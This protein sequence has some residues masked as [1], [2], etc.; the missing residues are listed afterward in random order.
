M[1]P[2]YAANRAISLLALAAVSSAVNASTIQMSFTAHAFSPSMAP[3]EPVSGTITWDSPTIHDPVGLLLSIDLALGGHSFALGEVGVLNDVG[4]IGESIVGGTVSGINRVD[5]AVS[6]F[7]F[8]I[9]WDRSSTHTKGFAY[10]DDECCTA[11]STSAVSTFSI[12]PVP[13]PTAV[14]LFGSAL[15]VM[16]WMRRKAIA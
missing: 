4:T 2:S 6:Q 16:G 8:W 10:A 1:S 3:N 15:G 5:G 9:A 12:A 7:D 13:I 14:W 11:W